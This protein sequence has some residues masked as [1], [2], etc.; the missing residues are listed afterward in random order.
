[1]SERAAHASDEPR[2]L[3][4]AN[5][6]HRILAGL[7]RRHARIDVVTAQ[8][9]RFLMRVQYTGIASV[10][11]GAGPYSVYPRPQEYARSLQGVCGAVA[12]W[13]AFARHYLRR[14]RYA[15]RQGY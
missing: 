12:A 14:S 10:G 4:D 7:A 13:R 2:F 5:F 6:S 9:V 11:E 3:T 15:H 1:M 8:E